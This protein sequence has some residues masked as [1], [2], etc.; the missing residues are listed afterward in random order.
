MPSSRLLRWSIA[1]AL[2]AS[3]LPS[4]AADAPPAAA[5]APARTVEST[6]ARQEADRQRLVAKLR[7]DA[8]KVHERPQQASP[9]DLP[10]FRRHDRP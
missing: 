8:P 1:G 10:I 3:A 7:G 5:S 6:K 2:W 9:L 4:Q